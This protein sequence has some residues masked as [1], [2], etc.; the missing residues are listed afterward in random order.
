MKSLLQQSLRSVS[1]L[2][3]IM[4]ILLTAGCRGCLWGGSDSSK[5]GDA[6]KEKEKRPDFVSRTPVLLPGYFPPKYDPEK[7]KE[8]EKM[9]ADVR[10]A[11]EEQNNAAV[12]Y[13]RH[14]LGH[15]VEAQL[16]V[17]ANN[18]NA[19][20]RLQAVSVTPT[21]QKVPIPSTDYYARTER[22]FA[23]T[24]GEWKN[25]EIAAFLPRRE[26]NVPAAIVDYE[27]GRGGG[28]PYV[29]LAQGTPLMKSFQYHMVILSE[30]PDNYNFFKLVDSVQL[31]GRQFSG[32]PDYQLRQFYFVV[33]SI[34]GEPVPL[35]RQ[36]LFWTT[37][38]YL[39]WDDFDPDKLGGDQQEALLDWL[40]FGGQ[41]I[42][43]GPD[44]LSKLQNSFLA[45]YLPAQ[46]NG[47]K[48]LTNSDFAELN[49]NWSI[50]LSNRENIGNRTIQIAEGSPLL[51][52]NFNPHESA[53]YVAG[54]G[55]LLIER[56]IGRGRIVVTSFSLLAP[57]VRKWPNFQS[58]VNGALLRRPARE[59]QGQMNDIQVR[60]LNDQTSIYDPLLGSTLRYL[61]RDLSETG[62]ADS[63]T[64]DANAELQTDRNMR[65]FY[66][67]NELPHVS[68]QRAL[69]HP[70]F[71]N[72]YGGFQDSAQS[73]VAG[74]ND[75]SGIATAA[76]EILLQSAGIVPPSS[77]F[78]LKMLA[79]YLSVLV[80]LNWL[81]F[82]LLGRVEWAWIAAPFIAIAGAVMVVK[83]AS[84]DIGF[85]RSNTQVGILEVHA[86]Y[87]RAHV[88][89]YSAL[90][91]SLSTNYDVELDNLT[92]QS[93]PF[94]T[95]SERAGRKPQGSIKGVTVK[96]TAINRL[97]GLPIQSNSTG[98]LHTEFMLDLD[99]VI[100]TVLDPSG[101]PQAVNNGTIVS[102]KNAGVLKRD[103]QGKL[104]LAWIGDL[105]AG[106][107]ADLQFKEIAEADIAQAWSTSAIFDSGRPKAHEL[108]QKYFAQ[109]ELA[110]L[111]EIGQLPELLPDWD[112]LA[113][114]FRSEADGNQGFVSRQSFVQ[115]VSSISIEEGL[116]IGR[117]F[118]VI[119]KLFL[120]R[121]EV[122][123][124]GSTDQRLGRTKFLPEATRNER[125]TLI[126]VHLRRPPLPPAK[127]DKNSPQD[128]MP[129]SNL[130]WERENDDDD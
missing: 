15:W 99:G 18:F 40:H 114:V 38:A 122:R 22:P 21:L 111:A 126:V 36:S 11:L 121:G 80:P 112:R 4:G 70:E 75:D 59:F 109:N 72:F 26:G 86:D 113:Q 62:T 102:I 14:K 106:V 39:I 51:G 123:L 92:A 56:Q 55:E 130:D 104:W 41:L 23:L 95:M 29:N 2:L 48:N 44:C 101:H 7:E 5:G 9:P 25:L 12:R 78:V 66:L 77:G 49:Q 31:R 73:G 35:P 52:L 67:G 33:P 10:I 98:L 115:A 69:D 57:A 100:N 74:W 85:V 42:L 68:G 103:D 105:P 117:L 8:K 82:R 120:P 17:V 47:S 87:P 63:P 1:V 127:R 46:F 60:W 108:W 3:L 107:S 16:S 13:N 119:Q 124:I 37:I 93:L 27:L 110:T 50:P 61:S 45:S 43:S 24:K 53:N 64:Y 91:T 76:R 71:Q 83:M 81:V 96:R 94:A 97:E 54:T 58:F 32:I 129:V 89:E 6:E 30:R 19:D 116:Q 90:Y 34:F 88:A 28:V 125:Q 79:I 118:E 128:F 84:L 20:G 65:S